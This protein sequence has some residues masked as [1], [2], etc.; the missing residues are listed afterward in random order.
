MLNAFTSCSVRLMVRYS[1]CCA[2]HDIG[3]VELLQWVINTL[4][5][6]SGMCV[7]AEFI[8]SLY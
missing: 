4:Y 8:F 7:Y 2:I 5:T 6:T 3:R 1:D